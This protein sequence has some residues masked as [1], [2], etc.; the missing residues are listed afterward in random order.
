MNWR[1]LVLPAA[2]TALVATVLGVQLSSGG[3]DFVPS[4]PRAA[5]SSQPPAVPERGDLDALTQALVVDGVRRASC[6]LGTSRE[7]L[8]VALPSEA[9]RRNLA[10]EL[11]TSDA[12]LLEAVRQGLLASLQRLE[13]AEAL[14]PVSSLM[15]D[16]IARLGLPGIAESAA[17][18]IPPGVIDELLPT[19]AILER[20]IR[21]VDLAAVLAGVDDPT[22]LEAALAPAIRD[23][24]VAE[25]RD[26]IAERLSGGLAGLAGLGG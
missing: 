20:A 3:R 11:G 4:P 19:G 25:A 10:R 21:D 18:Q 15:D 7:R 9:D 8:L 14:P 16:L 12:A 1:D 26:R 22:N 23:A 17:R 24:A 6:D 2:A 5:C 13:R